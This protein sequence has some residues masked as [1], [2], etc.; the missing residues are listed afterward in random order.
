M[1]KSRL[2]VVAAVLVAI[3]AIAAT[4]YRRQESAAIDGAEALVR[5]YSATLGP[6]DA[7]VTIV[8][9]LD[10]ECESCA[11]MHP[12]TKRVMKEFDGKVRLVIRYATFHGNSAYAVGLLEG[13]R[14]HEK[15]WPLL[16]VFFEKQP[17]WASHAAPRPELLAGYVE[18]LGVNSQAVFDGAKSAETQRRIRQDQIDGN[19]LGVRQTPTFF[20]NGRRLT[21]L[22][23]EPLRAA[24]QNA[25]GS[26]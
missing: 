20:V 13:A 17:E 10:P 5:P 22:G 12:I 26:R 21:S 14:A 23:Y 7:P 6:A 25:L 11:A 2:I 1:N 3:F 19:S 15:Y 16:D 18:A 9:F 24:V 8:E 4:W